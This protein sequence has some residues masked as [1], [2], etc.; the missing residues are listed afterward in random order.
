MVYL[1]LSA[2]FTSSHWQLFKFPT[3]QDDSLILSHII[4][5]PNIILKTK[6]YKIPNCALTCPMN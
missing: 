6:N 2:R 3:P 5:T 1:F 4:D